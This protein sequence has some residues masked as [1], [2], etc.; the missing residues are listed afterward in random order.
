MPAFVSTSVFANGTPVEW[1][2]ESLLDLGI[3]NI[4]LSSIHEQE[5]NLLATVCHFDV[6]FLTHNFF[7]PL[8]DRTILNI[9]STDEGVRRRSLGFIQQAIDFAERL[10]AAVYTIHPGFLTDPLGESRSTGNYDFRFDKLKPGEV[11]ARHAQCFENFLK[12]LQEIGSYLDGKDVKVAVETQGSVGEKDQVLLARREEME[13]F[14]TSI[15][16]DRIGINLNLGH[17]N[18]AAA[19][20]GFD[21]KEFAA[22]VQ[23]KIFVVEVTHNDGVTDEHKALRQGEWYMEILK[24]GFFAD[25]PL[26]FEGRFTPENEIVESYELLKGLHGA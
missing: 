23:S 1:A 19:A 16:N 20:W 26:I 17:L 2:V 8:K 15:R 24:D 21:R 3:T 6:H 5:E 13:K 11:A 12:S 10:G 25:V 22:K 18:L 14:L 4:E 7:P 9:A